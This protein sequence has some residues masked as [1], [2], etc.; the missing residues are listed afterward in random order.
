MGKLVQDEEDAGA[1]YR[2]L[3]SE[4]AR[5]VSEGAYMMLTVV[6]KGGQLWEERVW[7][8]FLSG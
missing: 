7:R 5:E 8:A 6:K 3:A 4:V 2:T 1:R